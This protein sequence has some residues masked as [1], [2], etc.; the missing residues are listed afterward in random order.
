MKKVA[1]LGGGF[2][3][4]SAAYYIQKKG[5]AVTVF[6]KDKVLG[7][8]AQ[9][10]T[11]PH[12]DW[13]LE[14]A[15]HHLFKSDSAI[16]KFADDIGFDG[17]Y[18]ERPQTN[19]LYKD[20]DNYRI[21]P[22]DSPQDFLRFPLLSL[23]VKLRAAAVLAGL[24]L[25]PALPLFEH[26]TAKEFCLTYMGGDMW[27]VFF[28]ELFRK[29]FGKY[30]GIILASFLWAR[31]KVRSK[32]LGYV[33]G[34][35]QAFIDECGN[36]LEKMGV[37]VH[38]NTEVTSLMKKNGQFEVNGE[39]FDSV[40]STL[41]T[42]LMKYVAKDVLSKKELGK[43][44]KLKY[45]HARVL[46]IESDKPILNETYWLNIMAK[47]IPIM[48]VGQH[49]NFVDSKHY[50][51]NHIA[52]IGY[53]LERDDELMTM[54]DKAL[55]KFVEPHLRVISPNSFKVEKIYSF[56]GPF[57]QPIFDTDFLENKPTFTTSTPNFYMA[58]LDMTYPQD[59]GTNYAVKL[60][61]EVA[62]FF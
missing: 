38:L 15:Y 23:P 25:S 21:I 26:Q 12:W 39:K 35:F 47:E 2:A 9:G 42:P 18:F 49:T 20:G 11:Q 50:G 53:Y 1:V 51:G 10:F 13:P 56:K 8:L 28:E 60:G 3:G 40:V 24:K 17:I 48:F 44:D 41:P 46:I 37:T 30:A 33:E 61:R 62:D 59:R 7:G 57:A 58:N 4:L 31:I 55:L 34:G 6:E 45:L 22:V 19:S 43:F 5:Y 52:Y 27:N 29:K 32:E 36:K 14:R 54:S 16:Q